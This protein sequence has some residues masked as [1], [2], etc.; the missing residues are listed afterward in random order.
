MLL[1]PIAVNLFYH[2]RNT[3][4]WIFCASPLTILA[5]SLIYFS[6]KY[7]T[8]MYHRDAILIVSLSWVIIILLGSLP[9]LLIGQIGSFCDALF[10]SS[11]GYTSTGLSI[12]SDVEHL[13][14]SILIYRALTQWIGGLGIIV[15]LV[16]I[17]PTGANT[18]KIYDNETSVL[19]NE[20]TAYSA[21]RLSYSIL[22]TY[23]A[24][25]ISCACAYYLFGMLPFDA[26]CHSLTTVST[27][28]LSNYNDGFMHFQSTGLKCTAII[29]MFIG[30]I[31]F[32]IISSIFSFRRVTLHKNDEFKAYLAILGISAVLLM[33]F[34]KRPLDDLFQVVSI[35]TTTGYSLSA[36]SM[37]IPPV[38]V[39]LTAMMLVGGCTGSTAGGIKVA[40]VLIIFRSIRHHI[41][42]MFRPRLVRALKMNHNVLS[43]DMVTNQVLMLCMHVVL[44][45][46]AMFTI[47]TIQRS[48]DV[49]NIFSLTAASISNAG[50]IL[51]EAQI[52]NIISPTKLILSGL[53]LLGRLE[54]YPILCLFLRSFWEERKRRSS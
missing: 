47:A 51:S 8:T 13:P 27:G 2:E 49:S 53:M 37:V 18:K 17:L 45:V 36:N 6:R 30:G 3:I 32:Q 11:S 5:I 22:A 15:L 54:I 44:I 14:K 16:L 34:D 31:N 46:S 21:K 41:E 19:D 50:V 9:Y 35:V 40:R 7:S 28:G 39:L 43:P 4:S 1:I 52:G 23:I 38:Y 42:H 10:E 20:L 33:I 24:L 12:I 48:M 25:T 26:V 29:F